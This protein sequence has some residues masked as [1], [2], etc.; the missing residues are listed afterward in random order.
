MVQADTNADASSEKFT[1]PSER[2]ERRW[3][4]YIYEPDN[5]EY[6]CNWD[7][8]D[9]LTE[10]SDLFCG[11]V[12]EYATLIQGPP[13]YAAHVPISFDADGDFEETEIQWFHSLEEAT[14]AANRKPD[15]P[16]NDDFSI[17]PE[18]DAVSLNQTTSISLSQ[19][20]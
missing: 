14:A 2:G 5:W 1:Q 10:D 6:T 3:P 12:R 11:E 8:R 4:D 9:N 15:I 19:G 16:S 18:S 7:D 20:E 17:E 13:V